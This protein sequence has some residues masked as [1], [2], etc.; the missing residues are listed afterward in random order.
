MCGA[1][2][3]CRRHPREGAGQEARGNATFA[4]L[5]ARERERDGISVDHIAPNGSRVF[6]VFNAFMPKYDGM[7]NSLFA[8]SGTVLR[9]RR[10]V[11]PEPRIPARQSRYL[12]VIM[13]LMSCVAV[14]LTS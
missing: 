10:T 8:H 12:P 9:V 2:T 1:E 3:K 4:V 7:H 5:D 14:T 11:G 6:L 13:A